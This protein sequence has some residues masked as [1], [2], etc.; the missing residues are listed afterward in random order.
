[1]KRVLMLLVLMGATAGAQDSSFTRLRLRASVVR[2]PVIGHIG[3]DWR[4]RTGAQLEI[5]SNVGVGELSLAAA[6]VA[7]EPTTGR[8]PF[9]ETIF[10]LSWLRPIASVARSELAVGGRLSDVRMDF[11]DPALVAG[12]RTE[13]EV[14]LSLVARGRLGV[15]RG[16]SAFI[17]TAAGAFMLSTR[18]PTVSVAAGLERGM[19]SPKWL[20]DFLR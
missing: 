19:P 18:T 2:M 3:D 16:F 14:L 7:F 4:A 12:L 13:E 5:G 9:T 11:D 1:M 17:E 10:S 15:G 6:R 8:P 20:R